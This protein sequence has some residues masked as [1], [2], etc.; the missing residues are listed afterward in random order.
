[1]TRLRDLSRGSRK[2]ALAMLSA[3]DRR[4]PLATAQRHAGR[5]VAYLVGAAALLVLL[6][7]VAA[8]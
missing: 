2:I 1:M 3:E 7:L 8:S 4:P 6:W 5:G